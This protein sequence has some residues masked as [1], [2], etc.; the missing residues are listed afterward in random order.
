MDEGS[1]LRTYYDILQVSRDADP[2]MISAARRTLLSSMKKHPDLG[3][4][5][6]EAAMINEAHD[7][8]ADPARR[9]AYDATLSARPREARESGNLEERRRAPRREIDATV[10]FCLDFDLCWHPARVRD[11]SVLGVRIQTHAPLVT[12][13][14]LVI[15][16]ANL[17]APAIHGTVKWARMFHPTVF[18]RVYEA[19]IEFSDRI[20]D[21]DGRLSV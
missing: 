19:G 21:V 15:A 6:S 13:Q 8:L 7:V 4:D 20:V 5:L 9:R 2:E 1:S 16:P 11:V 10:S 17:A 12:G 14:H 3:G 18:E